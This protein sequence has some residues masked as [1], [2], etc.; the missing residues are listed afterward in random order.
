MFFRKKRSP[1]PGDPTDPWLE[2]AEQIIAS[3]HDALPINYSED[4]FEYV[5]GNSD[6]ALSSHLERLA[7][8]HRSKRDIVRAKAELTKAQPFIDHVVTAIY[9]CSDKG[10]S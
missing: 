9:R 7:L 2:L 1:S 10:A 6:C 5:A 8:L 4:N 3:C